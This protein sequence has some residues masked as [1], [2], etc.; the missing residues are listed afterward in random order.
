[1]RDSEANCRTVFSEE[2]LFRAHSLVLPEAEAREMARDLITAGQ[3]RSLGDAW[4][5]TSLILL[6]LL[7][8][9][10]RTKASWA[11]RHCGC[12]SSGKTWDTELRELSALLAWIPTLGYHANMRGPGAPCFLVNRVLSVRYCIE[13]DTDSHL[14]PS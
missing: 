11:R 13:Q 1:M 2:E 7:S 12:V 10:T 6:T 8:H 14:I 5:Q 3:K 4:S 9:E